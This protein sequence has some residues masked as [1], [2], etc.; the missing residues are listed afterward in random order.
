V[1]VVL[2]LVAV[3]VAAVVVALPEVRGAS[4]AGAS[5]PDPTSLTL[6]SSGQPSEVRSLSVDFD[7]VVDPATDWA[8]LD[9]HLDEVGA[10]GVDLSA[11]RVEFTPFDWPAH[12]EAAAEPGTDHLA[13]AAQ[14]LGTAPDGTAREISLIVDAY[15]PRWIE[16]DPSLAG[17]APDGTP[18]RDGVSA[19]QYAT[20]PVGDRL[21]EYVAALGERYLPDQIALTEV[22][23]D[24]FS[25]GDDDFALFQQMTGL[26]DWP[27]T[28]DGSVDESSAVTAAW[29]TEVVVGLLTRVRAALDEVR[30]GLGAQVALA[31]DVRLSWADPARGDVAAGQDY[32]AL[33]TVVDRLVVWAYV[34][35]D[36]DP[37]EVERA[38]AALAAAGYDMSRFTMSVGL[39]AQV[40]PP[41]AIAPEVMAQT[42][43]AAATN[44]V[45]DVN[46]TPVSLMTDAHWTA[47]REVWAP[48]AR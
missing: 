15:V 2:S 18:A 37:Q 4:P 39:W 48:P 32:A 31:M 10:T 46:V 38:T 9:A 33:L 35:T 36:R 47:L 26:A 43:T 24:V 6:G 11:G 5:S 29:R 7:L 12:P 27:R 8:A 23:L 45:T 42:V 40:E 14:A 22:F 34:A 19:T 16:Q 25:Y 3:L 17:V 20:G 28:S 44:G 13:R 21:V 41:V 1:I 30:G